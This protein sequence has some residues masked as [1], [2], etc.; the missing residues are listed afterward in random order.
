MSAPL[1]VLFITA[2]QW[3]GDC[4]SAA[5]HPMVRTPHLDA[6]AAEGVRFARHFANAAPCGPSRASLHTGLYLQNHRSAIN[7]TPLAARH[8]NW[9][10]ESARAGYDPVLFGYTDTSQDPSGL[11]DD[12][13]RLHTYEGPLPGIR[14]LCML[15]GRPKA[16]TDWLNAQGYETPADLTRAYGHRL[17]GPEY[18][19]G[20]AHPRPLAFPAEV[21][22]TAFLAGQAMAYMAAARDPF[23]VHLSFLRP[24]PPFVA[25]EPYNRLYD[26]AAVPGFARAATPQLE[27]AQ[28][29]W[30]A[31]RLTRHGHTA[32]ADEKR[33]R[34]L[35]AVYFGLMNRVDD[36]IGRLMA[37]LRETGLIDSTL[38]IFTSDHGEEMGDHWLLGK[39]GYFD[40]SYHIPLII[41]D[42]RPAADVGRSSVVDRFTEN[43]DIMPTLLEAIGREP[44]LQCDG[45]SLAAFVEGRPEPANWRT[46][47][48]WEFDFR[49][50]EDPAA[51]SALDL[52]MHHC[53]LNVL[54]GERWKY[55]HFTGL[56]PLLF[57]LE[58]DPHEMT[59]RSRDPACQGVMLDCAQRLLSWRMAHDEPAFGHVKLTESGAVRRP[60]SRY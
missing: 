9:A 31:W 14:P 43:V 59:D 32:P 44:P 15:D 42:P 20:A 55:V 48:H 56:A 29:P 27:G 51:E 21:D 23:V 5:G 53:A 17:P 16:W 2:D 28:H 24:H 6:L 60:E 25:P 49:D 18:E 36:E 26:P 47:A 37:F 30:L 38:I 52:T 1:N 4:L 40:G 46:E 33:L 45:R 34:R 11:A 41:R 57:D 35:K 39:G 58:A 3:R 13:P 50:P 54:R 19:D 10:L 22:E 12:D 7:G 8:T